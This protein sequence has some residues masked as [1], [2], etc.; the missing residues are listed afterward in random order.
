VPPTYRRSTTAVRRPDR[1]ICHAG[2]LPASKSALKASRLPCRDIAFLL[3][4][5]LAV[6]CFVI[7]MENTGL[8][9]Q[10]WRGDKTYS[11]WE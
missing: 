3:N 9:Q 8:T 2:S 7:S 11:L 4:F 1:A 5:V 10:S 6:E